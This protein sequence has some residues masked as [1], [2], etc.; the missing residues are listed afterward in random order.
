M[1]LRQGP[2]I[3]PPASTE[4]LDLREHAADQRISRP[5]DEPS[6]QVCSLPFQ[7]NQL[8]QCGRVAVDH[9]RS[10]RISSSTAPESRVARTG[11]GSR[12]GPPESEGSS[13]PSAISRSRAV[14]DGLGGTSRATS[15][16]RSVTSTVSP[17]LTL[18]RYLLAFSRSS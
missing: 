10:S 4:N 1:R 8:E 17:A 5:V 2:H 12:K 7:E 16:P 14:R 6:P 3:D 13:F 18:A 15:V 11:V 9:T